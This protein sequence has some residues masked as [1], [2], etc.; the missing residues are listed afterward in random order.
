MPVNR[1]LLAKRG[2]RSYETRLESA[3]SAKREFQ[4]HTERFKMQFSRDALRL[5][6]SVT[7]ELTY[8]AECEKL[9]ENFTQSRICVIQFALTG[10]A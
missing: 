8:F 3:K 10:N 6:H 2:I 9:N 4:T 7:L 1:I 5:S